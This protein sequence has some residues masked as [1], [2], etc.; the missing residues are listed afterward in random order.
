MVWQT[1]VSVHDPTVVNKSATSLLLP[2]AADRVLLSYESKT[3]MDER[4]MMETAPPGAESVQF[5]SIGDAATVRREVGKSI[6]H[7]ERDG[8]NETPSSGG[9]AGTTFLNQINHGR[10]K[11]FLDRPTV[12]PAVIDNFDAFLSNL[13]DGG[14]TPITGKLGYILAKDSDI[15]AQ[16][17]A[18]K[19]AAPVARGGIDWDAEEI[20][21]ELKPVAVGENFVVDANAGTDGSALLDAIRTIAE[22]WDSKDVPDEERFLG[23]KPPQYNLLVQNQDLLNRQF[24]NNNGVFSMGTVFFAWGIELVKTNL[25]PQSDTSSEG[26]LGIRGTN[27]NVDASNVVAVAWQREALAKARSAGVS[28]LTEDLRFEYNAYGIAA[29]MA[30]GYEVFRP[31]GLG[32]I[33][34][35]A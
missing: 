5:E 25:L 29:E 10:R 26:T 1:P 13:R 27:Y 15:Y 31:L 35:A 17:L 18:I 11:V 28:V 6:L 23:L 20:A 24:G 3:I 9:L 8:T 33:A 30:F 14:R 21:D 19:G 2:V 22:Y 7:D 4:I 12:A 16:R 32:A 34:T